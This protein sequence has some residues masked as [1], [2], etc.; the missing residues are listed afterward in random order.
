MVQQ[1]ELKCPTGITLLDDL[2]GGGFEGGL[3]YLIFGSPH[4]TSLLQQ[5]IGTALLHYDLHRGV[6]V[7]DAN[8][9]IRPDTILSHIR[10]S[11]LPEPPAAHL[12][13][14]HVARAFTTDQLLSLLDQA[15]N[16]LFKID[17]PILFVNGLTHL[18]QEEEKE[19]TKTLTA[20][21]GLTDS[22]IFRRAQLAAYLKQ[23]AFTHQVAVVASADA[24]KRS[25]ESPLR[26]G[27][28][29][30]HRFH[31]LIHHARQDTIETFTLEK[32]PSRPWM[33]RST[34]KSRSRRLR[35]A[36]QTTLFKE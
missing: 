13:R 35:S 21:N 9:A 11:F 18:V 16:T 29:A 3:S 20:P 34:I 14:L 17:I 33:Q 7:I 25:S 27:Q 12:H 26:I 24:P 23:L 8:N 28:A 32:H 30:R 15:P 6:A 10:A 5:S 19:E 36:Y 1:Q 31:V 2:L 22:R 4:C